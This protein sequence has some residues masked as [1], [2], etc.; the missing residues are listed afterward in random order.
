M[1]LRETAKSLFQTAC[2]AADPG[3]A[4]SRALNTH[5]LPRPDVGGAY[6]IVAIGKA[7][8][9][10]SERL[11]SGLKGQD[12]KALVVTNYE[13]ARPV[14][15]AVVMASG[16]PVPDENG[17]KAAFAVEAML[18][19]ATPAD[20]VIA[21]IS[22]GGS[23]LL[24]APVE[25]VT[26]AD[27]AETSRLLLGA[28]V[29]ISQ[30][31]LVR[32]ALSRLKGGG[33]LRSAHPAPVTGYILSDVI[34]DDLR[35]IASGLTVAPAGSRA[36]AR[37]LLKGKGL[38]ADL[39]ASVKAALQKKRDETPLPP[40]QNLLIGS[41]RKSLEAMQ[42]AAGPGAVIVSDRLEGDVAD[43]AAKIIAAA[44]A[45]Q[46]P[47][48]LIFGGETTVRLQG[49][50]LG[51]RNQELALRVTMGMP[52]LGRDWV[53]LSGGTDGRDGPTDAAGGMVDGVTVARI[54]AAGGDPA[55]LLANNDSHRALSLAGDLLISGATGTNVADVQVLLLGATP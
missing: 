27:K 29:D 39:P 40:A 45:Q 42:A 16:H 21:L 6:R 22:G 49:T 37:A 1:D 51:G 5:P 11:I 28:G 30:L 25:G 15:G 41:N 12:F 17:A 19:D 53:F 32:Q 3:M 9:P 10:M 48:C 8:V 7:A 13:N 52:E 34:G 46:G 44:K 20:R 38:W 14:N 35:V 36:E 50:G 43:A 26:L 24:P 47:G 23:A 2:T 18:A 4:L 33:L 54:I 31:N 55:A